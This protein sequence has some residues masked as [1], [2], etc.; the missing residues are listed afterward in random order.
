[1][2]PRACSKCERTLSAT[3]RVGMCM[4]CQNS[5]TCTDCGVS[6]SVKSTGRCRTCACAI[7]NRDPEIRARKGA[8]MRLAYT[9]P[10]FAAKRAAGSRK[11]VARRMADPAHV[12]KLREMGR[13]YGTANLDAA[14]LSPEVRAKAGRSISA[15]KLE[16]IPAAYRAA[17]R[18]IRAKNISAPEAERMVLEQQEADQRN[19]PKRVAANLEAMRVKAA[20]QKAQAY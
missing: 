10:A 7:A 8:A 9:D 5:M 4:T 3:N 16:H 13:R 20:R 17:Y 14:R 19:A 18:E 1:M 6:I 11:A 12:E 2:K 15:R